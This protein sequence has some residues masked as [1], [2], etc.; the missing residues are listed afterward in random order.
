MSIVTRYD[1][2]DVTFIIPLYVDSPARVR[3]LQSNL[4]HLT[5]LFATS[6]FIGEQK[7]LEAESLK[8]SLAPF[9][10]RVEHFSIPS[11]GANNP[12]HRTKL[13]NQLLVHVSTPFV[14]ILDCDAVFSVKQY[15][16]A[17]QLLRWSTAEF[18]LPY[19]D[20]ALH[21]PEEAQPATLEKL[22]TRAL[23][24]AEIA[25]FME[26]VYRGY[27]VGGAIFANTASFRQCGGENENF[28]GWG[29]EDHERIVRLEKLGQRVRRVPGDFYHLSHP[30]G[31]TSSP[32]HDHYEANCLE[33]QRISAMPP[34]DLQRE[35]TSWLWF[36]TLF[37]LKRR[38]G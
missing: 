35:V 34:G 15:L 17:V 24:E 30:R 1:L 4:R 6:I 16:M 23:T 14:C 8:E 13:V 36:P 20:R 11:R 31:M 33:L 26:F 21:V 29:W 7:A 12:F 37:E 38:V 22:A 10:E 2:E 25:G 32:Q 19:S 27:S 28:V 5:L 9:S 3:N 18:V